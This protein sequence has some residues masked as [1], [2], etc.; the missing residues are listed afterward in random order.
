M[1]K[2]ADVVQEFLTPIIENLG[3][4]VVEVSYEKKHDGNHLFVYIDKPEGYI[5]INDCE[6]VHLAIDGPLDELNP[7]NDNPYTL[8]VSSPGADRP[9]VTNKDY[10]KNIGEIL[11]IKLY[12]AIEKKK[13]LVGT[14]IEFNDNIVVL[15][16]MQNKKIQID[17]KLIAK[18][19][20]YI[21]F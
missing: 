3:Y 8:N 11:E 2:V 17:R 14:L 18:A 10:E 1:S 15:E 4:E 20:K 12:E 16:N 21:D 13:L 6:K 9:I 7:T 19:T 5:D